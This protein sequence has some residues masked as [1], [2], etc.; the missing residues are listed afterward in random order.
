MIGV[1]LP[2]APESSEDG[3]VTTTRRP[4]FT[5]IEM[6]V[7][8]AVFA[9][10]V[11]LTSDLF[12][13]A[14]RQQRRTTARAALEEDARFVIE[15][16]VREVREG[17]LDR[18]VT[19]AGIAVMHMDGT[20][21]RLR[22]AVGVCPTPSSSCIEIGRVASDGSIAWASLT[23]AGVDVDAFDVQVSDPETQDAATVHLVLSTAGVRPDQRETTE[24][25]TTVVSRVYLR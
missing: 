17:T 5:L 24:A 7:A 12:L 20:G 4:A 6:L 10:V 2:A 19:D 13:T 21:T 14:T 1:R 22:T 11:G 8:I 25:Q 16:I 3:V 18:S 23:S 15:T 9:I